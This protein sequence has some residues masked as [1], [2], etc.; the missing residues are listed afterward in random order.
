MAAK[1][2][3][4]IL[5]RRPSGRVSEDNFAVREVAMPAAG[6]GDV[7]VRNIYLS[8]DPYMRG[9]MNAGGSY[10]DGFALDQPIP[11]RVVGQVAASDHPEFA[12]GDFVWGFLA[13]ER[14]SLVAQGQGLRPVDPAQGPISHFISVLGMPGLTAHVGM[15]EIGAPRPG[16]TVLV[17]GAAGAVGQLA[18]QLAK[19]LGAR[20]IGSAG[21]AEK[22][23]YVV[24]EL[25]FDAAYDYKSVADPGAALDRHCGDGIDVYFDNVGGATLDAVL[26][27]LNPGARIAACG[28]I[29]QYDREGSQ[30]IRNIGNVVGRRATLQG[31]IVGDHLEKLAGYIALMSG[32]LKDGRIR[33]REDVVGG[34]ENAPAAFIGMLRGDSIGK[35]LVQAGDDPTKR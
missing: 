30:P 15:V 17:S 13:W 4:V 10:A 22:V 1:N 18:G 19:R 26:A 3:Q 5:K 2:T 28:M 14:Y 29:S 6:A 24:D 27:R 12:V 21:S 25:G 11:A 20:V 33:Y 34:I 35:R 23:N 32:W 8:C 9:R 7:L 16:E 31:F